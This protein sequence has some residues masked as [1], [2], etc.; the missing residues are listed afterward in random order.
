MAKTPPIKSQEGRPTPEDLYYFN[1]GTHFYLDRF[2][3]ARPTHENGQLGVR[4]TVWAPN[5][6]RVAVIADFTGWYQ[7]PLPLEPVASSGLWSGFSEKCQVGDCYKYAIWPQ[8]GGPVLEKADP[9]AFF[10]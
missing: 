10:F 6:E 3:G 8:G 7:A 5:A 4:F 2:V 9:M 1:Q